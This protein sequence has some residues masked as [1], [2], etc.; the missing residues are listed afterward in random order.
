MIMYNK[1]PPITKKKIIELCILVFLILW[2]LIFMINYF[3]YTKDKPPIFAIPIG[4]GAVCDDGTV[5]QYYGMGYVYRKYTSTSTNYSEFVPFW[6]GRQPCEES[7]GLPI[8]PKD[9]DVPNNTKRLTSYRGIAYFYDKKTYLLG[10]YKCMNTED[11]CDVAKSGYDEFDI[12]ETDQL[13]AIFYRPYMYHL[14]EKYGFVDDSVEQDKK[15]GSKQYVRTIYYYDFIEH[16]ILYRFGDVKYSLI[17]EYKYGISD[18]SNRVIVRDYDNGKWGL[19][20]FKDN[21]KYKEILKFEY[22]SIN[23]DED[24]GY[25]ILCK[26][27]KWAIYDI[28]NDKYIVEDSNDVIYDIWQNGNLSYYYKTGITY[29]G[30]TTFKVYNINGDPLLE[31]ENICNILVGKKFIVYVDKSE[32]KV[33]F[34]DYAKEEQGTPVQ[35]YFLEL[36]S[37]SKTHPSF[38]YILNE[39][40]V[41][42]TVYKG[43]EFKYEYET[44][45]ESVSDWYKKN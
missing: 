29:E 44:H 36:T 11:Q 16:K 42:L 3:R 40:N 14:F 37:D 12:R 19:L 20:K 5:T 4:R 21:G 45:Q 2:I 24:T 18:S 34:L 9:F 22:D 6:K 10:A 13:Y 7:H 27:N 32:K 8:L 39:N 28:D 30:E 17:N 25:Y 43:R 15:Y 23:Y 41:T 1:R 26:D 31:K 35:L 33:H 38:T